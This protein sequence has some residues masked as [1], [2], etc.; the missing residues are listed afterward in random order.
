MH[1]SWL[2]A[3]VGGDGGGKQKE[4]RWYPKIKS[5]FFL[6]KHYKFG[7]DLSVVFT[8]T[9]VQGQ[10]F[11]TQKMYN[12]KKSTYKLLLFIISYCNFIIIR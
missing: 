8:K 6:H 2:V 3:V 11:A 4:R 7:Y 9:F 1:S 5:I 10:F 12:N